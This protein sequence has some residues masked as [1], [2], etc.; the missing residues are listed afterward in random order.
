LGVPLKLSHLQRSAAVLHLEIDVTARCEELFCD[1][2]MPS[3]GRGVERRNEV[4]VLLELYAANYEVA[5]LLELMRFSWC[6]FCLSLCGL[7][8]F[9]AGYV[10]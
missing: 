5:V 9:T 1:A 4:A 10:V 3:L 2:R 8:S 7:V 6:S